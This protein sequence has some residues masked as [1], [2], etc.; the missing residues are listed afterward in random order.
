MLTDWL[1]TGEREREKERGMTEV[2]AREARS[3]V[4]GRTAGSVG[5]GG[6]IKHSILNMFKFEMPIVHPSGDMK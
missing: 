1:W 3:K 5:S 6:K 2:F 4:S